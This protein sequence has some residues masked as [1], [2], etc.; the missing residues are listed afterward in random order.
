MDINVEYETPFFKFV[1]KSQIL[2]YLNFENSI[3]NEKKI[4][5]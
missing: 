3:I 1:D 5:D 4:D 2:D